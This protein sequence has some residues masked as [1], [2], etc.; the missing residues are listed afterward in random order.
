MGHLSCAM[1]DYQQAISVDPNYA[2]AYFS[3]ANIY[4]HNRQFS[5]VSLQKI[6]TVSMLSSENLFYLTY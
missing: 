5:Q 6:Y 3:A 2:L 4:F 1:K